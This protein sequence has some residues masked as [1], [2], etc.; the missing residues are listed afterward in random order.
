MSSEQLRLIIEQYKD[1]QLLLHKRQNKSFFVLLAVCVVIFL[2][3]VISLNTGWLAFFS[4]ISP[5]LYWIGVLTLRHQKQT[6]ILQYKMIPALLQLLFTDLRYYAVPKRDQ[7]E[8]LI[9]DS[10]V[11]P[12]TLEQ[13]VRRMLASYIDGSYDIDDSI[14]GSW[15]GETF[16]M[17]DI[18]IDCRYRGN[19]SDM[20]YRD[21]VLLSVIDAPKKFHGTTVVMKR[22]TLLQKPSGLETV[23]LESNEF[24][25]QFEVWSNDQIEARFCLQPDIMERI[26][27]M[28]GQLSQMCIVYNANM[29]YLILPQYSALFNLAWNES[30][31]GEGLIRAYTTIQ[32][33]KKNLRFMKAK[34]TVPDLARK[35]VGKNK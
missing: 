30:E 13:G 18:T 12:A 23:K 4:C 33:I 25:K 1:P 19:K 20:H 16:H 28:Q 8:Q 26:M 5:G 22:D 32:D 9:K 24:M 7:Y 21:D 15:E 14:Q 27:E 17:L 29:I 3:D 11:I 31:A 6:D 35:K 10:V 2:V 34:I